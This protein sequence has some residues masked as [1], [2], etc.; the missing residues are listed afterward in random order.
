M[1]ALATASRTVPL[2]PVYVVCLG[3]SNDVPAFLER[4]GAFFP[5]MCVAP[6]VF[7]GFIGEKPPRLYLLEQ[8]EVRAFWD[9]DTFEP[10]QIEPWWRGP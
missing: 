4:A 2:P 6:E 5:A 10:A 7:F 1:Q 8:G 3:S 9:R